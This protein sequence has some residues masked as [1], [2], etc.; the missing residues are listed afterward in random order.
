MEINATYA[1]T[2]QRNRHD[3]QT[4]FGVVPQGPEAPATRPGSNLLECTG[5]IPHYAPGMPIIL[6]GQLDGSCFRVKSARLDCRTRTGIDGLLEHLSLRHLNGKLTTYQIEKILDV[7]HDDIMAFVATDDCYPI[8]YDI[9]KRTK[10]HESMVRNLV[11]LIR[12]F[13][14]EQAFYTVLQRYC[15]PCEQID[16]MLRKG[17]TLD[18]LREDPYLM[19]AD[20]D[21]PIAAVDAFARRECGMTDYARPRCLGFV[22]AAMRYLVS[23]GHTCCTLPQLAET[24]NRRYAR[25]LGDVYFGPALINACILD[26][27]DKCGYHTIDG[28]TVIALNATWD[29]EIAAA[30]HIQRLQNARK[31]YN[32]SV[33]AEDTATEIGID[34]NQ[35]QRA[36]FDLLRTSG[37]KILTGPPGSGKTAV[38][39]GLIRNFESNGN[40]VVHLAATT[41]RAARVMAAAT[42]RDTETAHAMLRMTTIN[43]KVLGRDLNDPVDAD[44]IVVDEISM[45]GINLFSVLVGA[46]KSGSII[47]LVGDENQLQSVECGNVLHDLIASGEIE[48]C[49]LTEIMRQSGTICTNAAKVNAGNTQLDEDETFLIKHIPGEDIR[50]LLTADYD[51]LTSQ[52]ITPMKSGP[53]GTAALNRMIQAHVNADAPVAADYGSKVFRLGDKVIMTKTNYD[54]GYVNGDMGYIRERC[55]NGDLLIEFA[56]GSACITKADFCNMDL[57][58]AITIHKSQ[59]SEFS[60]VRIVLPQRARHMMTRRLLY[61]A[62]TRA[63][64]QVIIYSQD[65]SLQDAIANHAEKPRTTTL[66]QKLKVYRERW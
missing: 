16:A 17:V 14:Q 46:A 62:I 38:I 32:A 65:T 20:Y 44:L 61:T 66:A 8:L 43:D 4:H 12:K 40:G 29:A 63:Q 52:V 11:K 23:E 35:C 59:G 47:L 57:A 26:M 25:L 24:V 7:C 41:G 55:E 21:I 3:G 49:R 31:S 15:I 48:T 13:A 54:R 36:A 42:G 28:A 27:T 2:I 18:A 39:N 58:Y 51:P 19:M 50:D 22:Y 56:T 9:C 34:Y 53:L 37:I 64:K 33:T 5:K 30:H 1:Y 45:A 6:S 10:N 60:R